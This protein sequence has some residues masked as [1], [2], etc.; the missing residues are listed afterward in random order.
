[1]SRN[2]QFSTPVMYES[3]WT[4]YSLQL[5]IYIALSSSIILRRH[6]EL[7][8]HYEISIFR[9][10]ETRPAYYPVAVTGFHYR[11]VFYFNLTQQIIFRFLSSWNTWP[12]YKLIIPV[13]FYRMTLLT[14]TEIK[15]KINGIV[16]RRLFPMGII[17]N[18]LLF[19][20]SC[21][22]LDWK[23]KQ[24]DYFNPTSL[25]LNNKKNIVNLL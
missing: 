3:E 21:G 20:I 13:I 25:N 1:M 10:H 18:F 5:I 12:V 14:T 4:W 7:V 15:Q 16:C 17:V 9:M 22:K 23:Y 24:W 11:L 19:Y 2:P 8:D 6:N